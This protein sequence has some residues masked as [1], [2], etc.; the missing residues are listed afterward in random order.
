M[1]HM[2]MYIDI[3]ST[4]SCQV[5]QI[6]ICMSILFWFHRYLTWPYT[7]MAPTNLFHPTQGWF[8]FSAIQSLK[9]THPFGA[10]QGVH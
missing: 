7:T 6:L 5:N 9:R 2:H 3:K 4:R 1:N 10:L 8:L